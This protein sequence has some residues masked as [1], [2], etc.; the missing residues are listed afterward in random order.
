MGLFGGQTLLVEAV[1]G[2]VEDAEEGGGEVVFVVAGG[3]ADVAGAKGG[4]EGMGGGVDPAFREIEADGFGDFAIEDLLHCDGGGAEK[5][6]AGDF[7][8]FFDG[9]GGEAGEVALERVEEVGDFGGGGGAFVA[10]EK[11]GVGLV[12]IAPAVRFLAGDFEECFEMGSEGRRSRFRCEPWPRRLWRGRRFGSLFR[13]GLGGCGWSVRS[14]GGVRGGWRSAR[15]GLL[16]RR[17]RGRRE[18]FRWCRV[19]ALFRRGGQV[20]WRGG[21]TEAEGR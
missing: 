8:G 16:L 3:E 5:E 20:G 1:S 9:L 17:L 15:G 18:R 19:G 21:S 12:V 7:F 4:A 11:G 14:D 10:R 6:I 13:R 2:F